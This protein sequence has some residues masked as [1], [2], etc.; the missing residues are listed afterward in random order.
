MSRR[1]RAARRAAHRS[2]GHGRDPHRHREGLPPP[3]RARRQE[4]PVL[5]RAAPAVAQDLE[6]ARAGGAGAGR[7]PSSAGS[8]PGCRAV[9]APAPRRSAWSPATTWP[10]NGSRTRA[11]RAGVHRRVAAWPDRRPCSTGWPRRSPS[12][13]PLST[14]SSPPPRTTTWAA[15][16]RRSAC[17]TPCRARRAVQ[18]VGAR[19]RLRRA[20]AGVGAGRRAGRPRRHA[21][22]ADETAAAQRLPLGAGLSRPG[23]RMRHGRRRAGDRVGRAAGTGLLRRGRPHPAAG[24]PDPAAYAAELV[25]RFR[26]PAVRHRLRQIA[27]RTA[28]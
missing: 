9:S 19:G 27:A 5:D 24:R 20:P 22:P 25:A 10:D 18:A 4:G 1:R 15:R 13:P 14:G 17:G 8:R 28:R 12:P 3:P 21:L 16:R 23:G 7:R 2:R 26:N 11:R 6:R